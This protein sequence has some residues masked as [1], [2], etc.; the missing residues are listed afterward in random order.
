[1]SD[2]D[3]TPNQRMF[4]AALAKMIAPMQTIDATN[5]L[6]AML[7]GLTHL[8][9]NVFDQPLDLARDIA[10]DMDRVP[11]FARLRKALEAWRETHKGSVP[12]F[13]VPGVADLADTDLSAEDRMNVQL[14]LEH[15]AAGDL[16]EREMVGRLAI[17]RQY[18]NKGYKWLLRQRLDASM[19]AADIAV[20]LG[21]VDEE[22][23]WTPPTQE[24]RDA[25]AAIVRQRFPTSQQAD[26]LR[27]D[28]GR[29]SV[30]ASPVAAPVR[31][32]PVVLPDGRIAGSLKPEHQRAL[33]MGNPILRQVQER[34]DA[35]RAMDAGRLPWWQEDD[36]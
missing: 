28:D 5:A 17:V 19:R 36:A 10:H 15:D 2:L 11:T 30:S 25:V 33:R 21:W 14:W 29:V 18:A 7:P 4:A 32:A 31:P 9:A 1:M 26:D 8:P 20:R 34:E 35:L 3:P 22:H 6:M 23:V 24:E 16:T 12:K 13:T 27:A